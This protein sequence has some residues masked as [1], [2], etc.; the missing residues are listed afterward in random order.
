M[1]LHLSALWSA[2]ILRWGHIREVSASAGNSVTQSQG[3]NEGGSP[4]VD[5][6]EQKIDR[7]KDKV[8]QME[9]AVKLNINQLRDLAGKLE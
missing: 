3:M 4:V 2:I 7:L 5:A 9:W 6:S 8:E 1:S